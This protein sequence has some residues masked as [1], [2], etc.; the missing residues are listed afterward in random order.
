MRVWRV[1]VRVCVCV[2]WGVERAA[3]HT[4]LVARVEARGLVAH[5]WEKRG[6]ERRGERVHAAVALRL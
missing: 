6:E 2:G 5:L 4:R 1:R 3:E